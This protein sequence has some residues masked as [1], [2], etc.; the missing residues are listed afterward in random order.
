MGQILVVGGF[1]Y[2]VAK[3]V[4]WYSLIASI[5]LTR[6]AQLFLFNFVF[7]F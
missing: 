7:A 4:L 3:P 2:L 6:S 5:W 1:L